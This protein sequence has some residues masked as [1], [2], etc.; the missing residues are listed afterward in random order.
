MHEAV[1]NVI[2]ADFGKD[3]DL[4]PE[5]Y[6]AI[7]RSDQPA[8]LRYQDWVCREV[9]PAIDPFGFRGPPGDGVLQMARPAHGT[10][11]D[12]SRGNRCRRAS[13]A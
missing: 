4:R 12:D 7:M 10:Q 2:L 6:A 8:A 3:L 1:S 13:A 5:E 9:L 11:R